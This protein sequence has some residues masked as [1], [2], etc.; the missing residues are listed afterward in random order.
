VKPAVTDPPEVHRQLWAD[1]SGDV[2][3]DI[4]ANCG[5]TVPEM[6]SRFKVVYA[7]EPA[8]ECKPWL[9]DI[10][11][12]NFSWLPIALSDADTHAN[13]I[14]LPDKIDTGQL[15]SEQATGMEY[16]PTSADAETRTVICR[17]VDT[18]I[19]R[20]EVPSP[21]FMKIDVEGHELHVLAGA[22]ETLSIKRPDILLEFHSKALHRS[23]VD[24]LEIYDYK[25][26]TIRHPHYYPG[27]DMWMTHG[28]VRATQ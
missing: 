23:C 17:T 6:C 28:W 3:W 15:V 13:L 22:R 19:N 18:L 10:A 16:D 24:L 8:E 27:T 11:E 5:Q 1:C 26:F 20:G 4:G 7:F 14:V 25:T 9:D 21:D 12:P 2:G